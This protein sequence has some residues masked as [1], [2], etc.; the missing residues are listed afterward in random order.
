MIDY[1][2][3]ARASGPVTIEINDDAGNLV[4]RYSS[5]DPVPTPDPM[6][7]IP[8]Y[9]VRPPQQLASEPGMHRFLWDVRYA[10]VPG[11]QPNYPIAAVYLNTA[12]AATSP[13][14][15]PGNYTVVLTVNGKKYSQPMVVRM[16]PRLKTPTAD[17]AEQFRVSKQ[18]YDQ[19]LALASIT[20]N[21]RAIRARLTDLRARAPEGEVKT[22]LAALSEKLQALAGGGGG[23]GPGGGQG[24]A[25]GRLTV[26]SA[27]QRVRTLFNLVEEVDAAPTPQATAAANDI[28][29]DSR[30][31]RD[32]WQA[33]TTK[34]IP[35]LNELLRAG[36][37]PVIDSAPATPN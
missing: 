13:W 35:A 33:I 37:L 16:D 20:E 9:W 12:P 2:L 15:M 3:G 4:R 23:A 26:A 14:A 17:L 5:A 29:K 8:P 28:L 18:L 7:A 27:T 11:V 32:S 24:G 31:L 19:W 1:Y 36:G 34:D 10:P 21:V 6:L 30:S 25:A 22:S